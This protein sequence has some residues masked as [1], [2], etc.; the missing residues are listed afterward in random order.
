MAPFSDTVTCP[1][2]CTV[3]SSLPL[4]AVNATADV[5]FVVPIDIAL[6][7]LPVP[8]AFINM[9]GALSVAVVNADVCF[10]DPPPVPRDVVSKLIMFADRLLAPLAT[11][12]LPVMFANTAGFV[13][14]RLIVPVVAVTVAV[15]AT[16]IFATLLLSGVV[17]KL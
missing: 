15:P 8:A 14:L 3:T 13:V 16:F 4:F 5:P 1:M 7:A 9:V 6:L 12:I 2:F 17:V 10:I 11:L